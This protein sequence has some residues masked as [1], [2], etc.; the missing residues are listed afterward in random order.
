MCSPPHSFFI[1]DV[2]HGRVIYRNQLHLH[3]V[4]STSRNRRCRSYVALSVKAGREPPLAAR[5]SSIQR[6][7]STLSGLRSTNWEK[8]SVP[9]L[10]P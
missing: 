6:R 2:G 5:I 1:R 8:S 7:S 9:R 10:N 4:A 3:D